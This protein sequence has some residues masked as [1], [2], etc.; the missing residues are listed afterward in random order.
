MNNTLLSTDLER[1]T[2][3][4]VNKITYKFYDTIIYT[5]FDTAEMKIEMTKDTSFFSVEGKMDLLRYAL[6]AYHCWIKLNY[7]DSFFIST[8]KTDWQCKP[9]PEEYNESKNSIGLFYKSRIC[10][11]DFEF[12]FNPVNNKLIG[13]NFSSLAFNGKEQQLKSLLTRLNIQT[14]L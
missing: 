14:P 1:A 6:F 4:K 13:I 12:G 2:S 7:P 8:V 5:F 9:I 11:P 3:V 10:S